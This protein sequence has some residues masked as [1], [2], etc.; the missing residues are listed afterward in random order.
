MAEAAAA[1][2]A[3][4]RKWLSGMAPVEAGSATDIT[5]LGGPTPGSAG[6][7]GDTGSAGAAGSAAVVGQVEAKVVFRQ[8]M[9]RLR[10]LRQKCLTEE[11]A[12]AHIALDEGMGSVEVI[13]F[14]CGLI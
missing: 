2:V 10:D 13:G 5:D 3:E 12:L 4:R 9:R 7:T 11:E 8:V 6:D 14:V 1:K